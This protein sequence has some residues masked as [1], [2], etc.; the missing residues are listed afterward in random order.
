MTEAVLHIYFFA[1]NSDGQIDLIGY[2]RVL[3][4]K[5]IL[6]HPSMRTGITN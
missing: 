3:S 6:Y 4:N 5:D 2:D 1:N